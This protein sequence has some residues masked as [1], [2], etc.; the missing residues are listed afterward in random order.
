MRVRVR[1]RVRVRDF[2]GNIERA[3]GPRADLLNGPCDFFVEQNFRKT[4]NAAIP[5]LRD[6]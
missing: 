1:V 4:P 2:F 6:A 3:H 5:Y